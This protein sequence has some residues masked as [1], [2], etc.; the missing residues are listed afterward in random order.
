MK[1]LVEEFLQIVDDN[2]L[3]RLY[4]DLIENGESPELLE[5]IES[6]M[7]YL[8]GKSKEE[9]FVQHPIIYHKSRKWEYP[10]A[11]PSNQKS[12][13]DKTK[14]IEE[15]FSTEV[16]PNVVKSTDLLRSALFPKEKPK[17]KARFEY[18]GDVDEEDLQNEP[19]DEVYLDRLA[20]DYIDE[21]DVFDIGSFDPLENRGRVNNPILIKESWL[22]GGD[23]QRGIGLDIAY[24]GS[25]STVFA[26]REGMHVVDMWSFVKSDTVETTNIAGIAI[27]EFK[28]NFLNLDAT[29]G[30]GAAVYDMMKHLGFSEIC[31]IQPVIMNETPYS[32]RLRA[33]NKRAE[34]YLLLQ[35]KFREGVITI[36]SDKD[37]IK[38]LAHISYKITGDG[39]TIRISPKEEIKKEL[40]RSPDRADA[41]ALA[42]YNRPTFR[43]I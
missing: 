5:Q 19:A 3:Y 2:H 39:G 32:D 13:S 27:K 1:D 28:P 36:P 20:A 37:L 9:S 18:I 14:L 26:F 25:D 31:K 43:M 21:E 8:V 24:Y 16:E 15:I 38:E 34:M 30:L 11:K 17:P 33:F 42:F 40:G 29:G 35:E 10:G 7:E 4:Q 6:R 23:G 41:L 22:K 12:Q